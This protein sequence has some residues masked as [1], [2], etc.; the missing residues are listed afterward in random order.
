MTQPLRDDS[1]LAG[2]TDAELARRISAE[3]HAP[4]AE[5]ELCRRL[6]PRVRLFG[7][8]HLRDPQAAAELAQHV[9]TLVLTKLR[10]RAL[11]K[12]ES[13]ASFALGAARNAARDLARAEARW[14]QQTAGDLVPDLPDEPGPDAVDDERLRE[15]LA[16]LAERE[17]SVVV[18][19]FYDGHTGPQ[20]ASRLGLSDGNVRVIRSRALQRLRACIEEAG[21]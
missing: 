20:I 6:L 9:M 15:C 3:G 4:E 8:R 14:R 1:T 10:A 11:S 13:V 7:L 12:P 16:A 21:A 17:R 2:T 19:T 5:A 18:L